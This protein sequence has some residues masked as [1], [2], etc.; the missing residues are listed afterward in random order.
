MTL[1]V[2]ASVAIKW[3]I[4]EPDSAEAERL[5]RLGRALIAPDLVVVEACNVAWK[6]LR[7]GQITS[8]QA[9]GVVAEVA[10]FF[11]TL[12]AA[13]SL[14]SRALTIAESLGHLVYDCFYLALAEQA[15]APMVT[16]D[17]RL[18]Q[19]LQGTAW[20]ARAVRLG[21]TPA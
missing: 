6:K 10:D 2:D 17:A 11:D 8:A 4:E 9:A 18:L 14:A 19:R 13:K 7:L 15:G 1:V 5:L 16:A 21:E 20:R 12:V 3:S